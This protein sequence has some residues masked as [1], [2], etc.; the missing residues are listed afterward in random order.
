MKEITA[1]EMFSEEE[2]GILQMALIRGIASS[3]QYFRENCEKLLP[4]VL[5]MMAQGPV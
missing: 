2:L 4:K 1:K 5:E 3:N